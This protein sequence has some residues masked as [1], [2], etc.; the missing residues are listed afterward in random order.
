MDHQLPGTSH[1]QRIAEGSL[2]QSLRCTS[3]HTLAGSPVELREGLACFGECSHQEYSWTP[4]DTPQ[5]GLCLEGWAGNAE[6]NCFQ[7]PTHKGT[8]WTLAGSVAI[9]STLVSTGHACGT[10]GVL[11]EVLPTQAQPSAY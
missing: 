6:T 11:R 10:K 3:P 9:Q 4:T 7:N 5:G 8:S 2:A 1:R